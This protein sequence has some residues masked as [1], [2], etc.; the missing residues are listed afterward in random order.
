M[1]RRKST[2][3]VPPPEHEVER[4]RREVAEG[5][6]F[7]APLP[8]HPDHVRAYLSLYLMERQGW[9]EV[10]ELGALRAGYT[11]QVDGYPLPIHRGTWD[12][13]ERPARVLDKLV[14][15]LWVQER[16]DHALL[17]GID[18]VELTDMCGVY[19]RFEAYAPPK[20]TERQT[21]ATMLRHGSF[22]L[23]KLTDRRECRLVLAVLVD[24][25]VVRC[26]QYRDDPANVETSYYHLLRDKETRPQEFIGGDLLV[27]L[28]KTT[29]GLVKHLRPAH[30]N[31][32]PEHG[33]M[34]IAAPPHEH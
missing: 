13:L 10:P 25:S 33:G 24:G 6:G 11:D 32:D 4:Q 29:Y 16:T 7:Y 23:D 28:L 20:G 18:P 2:R 31:D 8:P 5:R 3:Y 17:R 26:V 12:A 15:L 30:V 9:D 21:L 1:P 27:P 14:D 22:P 34:P 19:F